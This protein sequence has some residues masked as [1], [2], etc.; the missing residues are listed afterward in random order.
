V[1]KNGHVLITGGAGFIGCNLADHLANL[2]HR[3]LIFDSLARN[4]VERNVRWLQERHTTIIHEQ[5]DILDYS[6]VMEA[7]SEAKVVFHFAAQ[8][9]VTTSLANPWHDFKVN[10]QGTLNVLEAARLQ[11][12][13]VPVIFASTNKVY[14]D[15]GGLQCKK[16]GPQYRPVHEEMA[17]RGI[18]EKQPLDLHSPYG[19]SKGGA[20]QYVLDYARSF[21]LRTAVMRMSCI[22]G[23]RQMGTEDQG[24][25][26][27]FARQAMRGEPI[28]LYGDGHQVRDLLHVVDAVEAYVQ[29][30]KNI[31]GI[32]GQAF[33]LGGGPDN[34]VSLRE[35]IAHLE[36]LLN[37][38][39]E[40]NYSEWRVG[41]Q[42]YYVSN[43]AK[44]RELLNISRPIPWRNGVA[45]LVEWLQEAY[46]VAA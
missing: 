38:D 4:G 3:V 11:N 46:S 42:L 34:A 2:G 40:V 6:S 14:G 5:A 22:Y 13:D 21:G 19:C 31:D 7:V 35:L 12:R 39:I 17:W 23:P 18:S 8:V 32:S 27:H 37:R 10:L 20:E 15:L 29:A 25:V 43:T 30:W 9:A 36:N 44:L 1:Q 45:N 26:A 41:D 28:T 24:W 33:N 16:V